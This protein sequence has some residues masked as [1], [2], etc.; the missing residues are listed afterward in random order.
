MREWQGTDNTLAAQVV[1]AGNKARWRNAFCGNLRTSLS[2]LSRRV[3]ATI[4]PSVRPTMMKG[5]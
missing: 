2:V 3:E 5:G 4:R 1:H